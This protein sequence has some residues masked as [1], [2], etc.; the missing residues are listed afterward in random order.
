MRSP[1]RRHGG[2]LVGALAVFLSP[3][4]APPSFNIAKMLGA[5]GEPRTSRW[6]RRTSAAV[7]A[8]AASTDSGERQ[9]A[10]GPVI[11]WLRY[12]LRLADNPLLQE[13]LR[14]SA[15]GRALLLVFCRDPREFAAGSRTEFG[16]QKVGAL[17]S[18]FVE[19]SLRDMDKQLA[20]RGSRLFVFDAPPEEVLPALCSSTGAGEVHAGSQFCPEERQAERATAE[21]LAGVGAA[22]RLSDPGGITA[23]LSSADLRS[24]GLPG[25]EAEFPEDFQAFYQPVR[26]LLHDICAQGLAEAPSKL[27]A[28][29][30]QLPGNLQPAR[31]DAAQGSAD[32][33]MTG[34]ELQAQSRLRAW[35]ESGMCSYKY[36]FR[37]L[38][39]D[40]SSRL[41]PY[42]VYGCLS[43]RRLVWTALRHPRK[44]AAAMHIEHFVYEMCWR[45][46]F[47][48][49]A[50]RW[51]SK[52][53]KRE[54]P[55]GASKLRP[56][57]RDQ[58]V[59]QR[60]KDGLTGVPLVDAAM[61]ELKATG[62]MGVRVESE[63]AC[64]SGKSASNLGNLARQ[65][66]AAFLIEELQVDWR[67]GAD[68][69]E[70]LLIDYEPHSNW[71]QWARSA[72]VVPT[73]EAK[74]RRVG[75]TRYYDLARQLSNGEAASYIR[76]WVPELSQLGDEHIFAPWTPAAV[77]QVDKRHHASF[78]DP[79]AS[80]Q[81]RQYFESF[82]ELCGVR[83]GRGGRGKGQWGGKGKGRGR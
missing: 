33:I 9:L 40:Y 11:V 61:R 7:D 63:K 18:Q 23:M 74:K 82:H 28:V 36:T 27:P 4:C 32:G 29:P 21:A 37:R 10:S 16:S 26:S 47:R 60:W 72:G 39:G 41:S 68:W 65:F 77:A 15:D 20:E 48:F 25:T 80:K 22:L 69:F 2:F 24:A 3:R 76:T 34:G 81:L 35:M 53:F 73:N 56:W 42:L 1:F 45:D 50:A 70:S 13:G 64:G 58:A 31:L 62:Y 67:V 71:G 83:G 66:A 43:P 6:A 49:T 75:G 30:E 59:E 79:L 19:E 14:L 78:S 51:G 17:R 52:L 5:A 8:V 46:F 38:L 44:D 54:G 12:E 55:L 57:L